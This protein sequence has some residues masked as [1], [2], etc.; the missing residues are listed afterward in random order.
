MGLDLRGPVG[1]GE[2]IEVQECGHMCRVSHCD[3]C[4][5]GLRIHQSFPEP[6]DT[7]SVISWA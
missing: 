1:L 2:G 7:A 6:R 3:C 5:L 4:V